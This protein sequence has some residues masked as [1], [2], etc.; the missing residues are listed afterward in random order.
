MLLIIYKRS[1]S[2]KISI[3]LQKLRLISSIRSKPL[4]LHSQKNKIRLL[5]SFYLKM[6][7]RQL[8]KIQKMEAILNEMNQTL[9]EVNVAFEKRKALRPQIKELLK[10]YESKARFRDAEAS[11]R[12]ELPEDMPYGVLS[13]DGAW[14][15]FVCE[16]QLAKQLQ[17]FTKSVLKR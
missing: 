13:E 17:K 9:E 11:N 6:H 1:S 10:Y 3:L 2:H 5:P 8:Q 12:G 4:P 15:A 14:N 16:Y 7:Q